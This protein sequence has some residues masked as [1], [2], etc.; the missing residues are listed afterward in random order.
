MAGTFT[1]GGGNTTVKFE[2]TKPTATMTAVIGSAAHHLQPNDAIFNGLTNQQ[3]L[4][5]VDAN[6]RQHIIN[7]A[8]TYDIQTPTKATQ[9]SA[10]AAAEV[11]VIL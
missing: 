3:K 11:N 6:V 9:D 8:K 1:S 10:V 7:M 2:W 5:L 4:D